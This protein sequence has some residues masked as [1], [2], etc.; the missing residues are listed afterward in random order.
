MRW[1][2][3]YSDARNDPKVQGLPPEMFRSWFNLCCLAADNDG[4]IP[5]VMDAAFALHLSE[6]KTVKTI[7]FLA[8]AGLLDA[9]EGGYF[10]PHNW[11]VRQYRSDVSTDRVK[12]FR[13]RRGN[14]KETP[15]VTPTEPNETFHE[16]FHETLQKPFMERPQIQIQNTES[17]KNGGG[18]ERAR[19]SGV[20]LISRE[21]YDFC[22]AVLKLEGREADDPRCIGYA[23]TLQGWITKGWKPHIA[24]VAI[25]VVMGARRAKSQKAP[26]SLNY[27][28]MAIARAHAEAAQPLPVANIIPAEVHDARE[29]SKVAGVPARGSLLDAA[30]RLIA[31]V[32]RFDEAPGIRHGEGEIAVRAISAG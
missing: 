22:D 5:S 10:E 28:E 25:A 15:N 29:A 30:D 9:V 31:T 17:D 3:A 13:E 2:R 7:A 32:A 27:Y 26:G 6:A 23:W 18:D 24:L 4:K 16:T 20:G 14:T 19:A 21:A 1:W 8:S 12:A 11:S